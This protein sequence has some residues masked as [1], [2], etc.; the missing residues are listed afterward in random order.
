VRP[1]IALYVGGMGAK[2][3]NF[4]DNLFVRLGY[5]A[6]ADRIQEPYPPGKKAEAAAAVPLKMVEGGALVG[7]LPKVKDGL[8]AWGETVATTLSV[9]AYDEAS[10]RS[11]A[12]TLVG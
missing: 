1:F 11:V 3:A 4:Y 7:P 6:E 10:L 5:E 12:Q 8:Q 9:F 2:G